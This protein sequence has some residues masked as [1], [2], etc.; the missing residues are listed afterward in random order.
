MRLSGK[1]LTTPADVIT[2]IKLLPKSGINTLPEALVVILE[3]KPNEESVLVP[4]AFIASPLP[5]IEVTV[6]TELIGSE[7][8]IRE[9]YWAITSKKGFNNKTTNKH[10][11]QFIEIEMLLFLTC[12]FS[13]IENGKFDF[14]DLSNNCF[15]TLGLLWF[16]I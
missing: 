10:L 6:A 15:I 2:Q 16:I 8:Q 9:L 7:L 5:A 12:F 1:I 11:S 13:V 14:F 3:G 4:L